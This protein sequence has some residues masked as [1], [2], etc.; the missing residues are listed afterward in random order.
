[1]KKIIKAAALAAILVLAASCVKVTTVRW[2]EGPI[3]EATGLSQYTITVS[4][5]PAGADW[6]IW[7]SQFRIRPKMMEGSEGTVEH[8]SG[9]LHKLTPSEVHSKDSIVISYLASPL[10][11]QSWAPECFVLDIKGKEPQGLEATYSFQPTEKVAEF[12]YNPVELKAEDMIPA[13]KSVAYTEGSTVIDP[14]KV[15]YSMAE[16]SEKPHGWYSIT[17]ADEG[18]SA[19]AAD[20]DGLWYAQVTVDNLVRNAAGAAVSNMVIE[21]YPD[22]EYRGVMLDV[23]RNFTT[24]DNVIKLI[25]IISHYKVNYLHLHLA[26]DEGWRLEF[27]DLPELTTYSAFHALPQIAEDGSLIEKDALLTSYAGAWYREQQSTSNG[28]YSKADFIEILRYAAEHHINVI[29][30]MDVPGHSRAVIKA[31]EKYAE[32]TGDSSYLLSEAADTSKY[33]SV[34]YYDDNAINVALPSTYKF[35]EKFFDTLI[36]YYKEADAPLKAIHIG[37][38][39]VANGA[40]TGSPSCLKLM[41]ANGWTTTRELKNYF[42]N[43]IMD[44]AEERGVKIAGWQEV[45]LHTD[46]ATMERFHNNLAFANCWSTHRSN[47]TDELPYIFANQGINAILSNMTNAYADF[48]YNRSKTEKGHSWGGY[49]DE[50]RSFSLNPYDVY[51]SVRWDDNGEMVDIKD[52]SVDKT[53]LLPEGRSHLIGVQTQLWTETIRSFDDVTYFLFP[54]MVGIFERGW[55]AS[56]VW[57]ATTVSNDSL[58]TDDFNRFYSIVEQREYPYYESKGICY[59]KHNQ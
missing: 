26:D 34:Q 41:E 56:P 55:N 58:F 42:L 25:D 18:V 22:M 39:E 19:K 16:G 2:T 35:M 52:L 28:Y 5:P 38:D 1:M 20:K 32:R 9:S 59:R 17:I 47:R 36:A 43:R 40:W 13:L 6:V 24:K 15:T 50:R 7:F 44:I 54:K 49:V 10:K 4:N 27:E 8:I 31:M 14:A 48:A 29:T 30:E 51:K 46:E 57:A 3:D 37:G 11:R 45:A 23:A 21:D 12:Q 33:Y 53:E